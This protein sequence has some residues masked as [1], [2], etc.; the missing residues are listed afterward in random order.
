[1]AL[2]RSPQT[3]TEVVETLV[4]AWKQATKREKKVFAEQIRASTVEKLQNAC[5]SF[6]ASNHDTGRASE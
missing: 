5:L 3:R 4:S 2:S 6:M 1:M